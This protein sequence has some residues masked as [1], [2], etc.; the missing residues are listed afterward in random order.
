MGSTKPTNL[1]KLLEE[2]WQRTPEEFPGQDNYWHKYSQI[3]DYLNREVHP[4][5]AAGSYMHDPETGFLTD[6]G[7]EHIKAVISRA[8]DLVHPN[9]E[10][11][12]TPYE[13]FILLLA[14]HL[15][16]VGNIFGRKG[17]EKKHDEVIGKLKEIARVD[18][19]EW[20]CIRQIAQAHGGY[21]KRENGEKDKDKIHELAE[22]HGIGG[23]NV[24]PRKIAAILRFADEMAEERGRAARFLLDTGSLPKCSQVFHKYA[25]CI[26]H[27]E[28]DAAAGTIILK[29]EVSESDAL[30]QY[31]KGASEC[32]LIDEIYDRTLKTHLECIY[33]MRFTRSHIAISSIKV[34]IEI[35]DVA[36]TAVLQEISYVLAEAGYP[37]APEQGIQAM[38]KRLKTGA[39]IKAELS[40]AKEQ[41]AKSKEGVI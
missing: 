38:V 21:I 10:K 40:E 1:E 3:S 31:G 26:T 17:H 13:I 35:V 2:G 12:L 20:R 4:H 34:V 22:K 15:H 36:G 16:D 5:V 9:P 27:L 11:I 33:C 37:N 25:S 28:I 39:E 7:P 18:N 29:Y 41:G 32:F 24:F 6:H 14:A 8:S 30:E 23:K 19:F